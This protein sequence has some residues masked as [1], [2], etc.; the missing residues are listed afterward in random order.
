[1]K[2]SIPSFRGAGS[3][4]FHRVDS[5]TKTPPTQIRCHF[6]RHW[7]IIRLGWT[8]DDERDDDW[9]CAWRSWPGYDKFMRIATL[10]VN[11]AT[12]SY[13]YDNDGVLIGAGDITLTRDPQTGFLVGT[14]LGT[15]TDAY[16]YST[17]GETSN[18]I[19]KVGGADLFDIQYTRNAIGRITTK[20]GMGSDLYF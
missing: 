5:L 11:G 1:M 10:T 16:T 2:N 4:S 6:R 14:A 20:M 3:F 17:F 15:I 12:A 19:A 8:S 13:S 18:Y 7:V 9:A